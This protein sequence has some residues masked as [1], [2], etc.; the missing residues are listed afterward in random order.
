MFYL[1]V[2]DEAP[3]TIEEVEIEGGTTKCNVSKVLQSKERNQ[4]FKGKIFYITPGVVPAVSALREVIECA[5]GTVEKQRRSL[6]NIQDMKPRTYFPITCSGDLHLVADLIQ[7]DC[8]KCDFLSLFLHV[9]F[10]F[11]LNLD[12]VLKF[13]NEKICWNKI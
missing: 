6:K 5:G 4:L 10:I 7:N 1:L 12:E 11:T 2:L 3:Y 13:R 9:Y 8:G